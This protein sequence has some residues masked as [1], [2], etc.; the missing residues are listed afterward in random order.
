MAV[1]ELIPT[2]EERPPIMALIQQLAAARLLV[3]SHNTQTDQK[4]SK[5]RMRR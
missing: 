4:K 3:T 2:V 5:W 1:D